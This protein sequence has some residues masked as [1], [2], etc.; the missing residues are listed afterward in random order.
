MLPFPPLDGS[1][2]VPL[3]L[4]DEQTAK[5]QQLIWGRPGL[6][7]MGI[8]IAWYSFD[9]VFSPVWSLAISILL[10]GSYS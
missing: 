7:W 10:P 6:A 1:G 8:L 2:A 5:Y 3:L 9:Y 4:N